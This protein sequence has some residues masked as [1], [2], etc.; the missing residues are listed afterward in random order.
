MPTSEAGTNQRPQLHAAD[1]QLSTDAA[2][3]CIVLGGGAFSTVKF[4]FPDSYSRRLENTCSL[5]RC[6]TQ[7]VSS[8]TTSIVV[9]S[10][11][12]DRTMSGGQVYRGRH[13]HRDVAVKVLQTDG[14]LARSV[15]REVQWGQLLHCALSG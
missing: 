15:R 8:L 4:L 13:L 14:N 12:D 9:Q 7:A 6:Y 1:I 11:S 10:C 5:V 3:R 2:G